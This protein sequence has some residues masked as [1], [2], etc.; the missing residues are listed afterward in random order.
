MQK[1][2]EWGLPPCGGSGLK[3]L[4]FFFTP[5]SSGLPPCGGSGLK[6]EISMTHVTNI[7]LPPCGGSGLKS[8][9]VELPQPAK[10]SPSMRREWIEIE[11]RTVE[12]DG[13]PVSLH[14]EG[15]D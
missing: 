14:A 7:G 5:A 15:V 8:E 10:Q 4:P 6:L 3:Y 2:S 9:L 13:E 12:K 1:L 11:I